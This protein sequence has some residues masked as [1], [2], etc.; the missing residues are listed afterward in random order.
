[1]PPG[2]YSKRTQVNFD[3]SEAMKAALARWARQYD[4]LHQTNSELR[5]I[6]RKRDNTDAKRL[7]DEA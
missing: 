3:W 1:M 2:V 6:R 5:P 4:R 7:W